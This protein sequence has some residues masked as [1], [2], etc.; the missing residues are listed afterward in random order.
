M[1]SK[2]KEFIVVTIENEALAKAMGFDVG[3]R[4]TVETKRGVPINREWRN[5]LNDSKIDGCV[6]MVENN[7]KKSK[8]EAK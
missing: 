1:S 3:E 4:V 6:K 7:S 2:T 5:R 8:Q